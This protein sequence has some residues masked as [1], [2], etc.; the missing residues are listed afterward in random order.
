MIKLVKKAQRGNE[1]A[2]VNL[3]SKFED[4]I[5]RIAYVYVK[6]ESDALDIVQ[7]VAYLSFKNIKSVINPEYFKTWIIKIT[8]TTSINFLKKNRKVVFLDKKLQNTIPDI[9]ED[10]SLTVTI[11]EILEFLD[12]EE[13]SIILL[14]YYEGY[15][16]KEIALLLDIP[17]GTAKSV[18]YR[19]L[20]K[21]RKQI[22]E[23]DVYTL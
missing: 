23:G 2:F 18:L 7:E 8:I 10:Y 21:L 13:K 9:E 22:K 15:S 19:A 3:F 1:T 17:L 5:Y 4:D 14:K 11:N 6:N 20:G 12:E 16:F